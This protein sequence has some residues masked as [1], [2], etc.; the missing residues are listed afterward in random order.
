MRILAVRAAPP[1]PKLTH[2]QRDL[3]SF[4]HHYRVRYSRGPSME[5]MCAAMGIKRRG[6]NGLL[7]RL[8]RKGFVRWERRAM[9]GVWLLKPIP[10][11]A[12]GFGPFTR[13]RRMERAL[14]V[15]PMSG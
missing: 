6:V 2:R 9:G 8:E 15:A 4:I 11:P 10:A 14:S 13:E 3:A 1:Q 5:A 12:E 7:S